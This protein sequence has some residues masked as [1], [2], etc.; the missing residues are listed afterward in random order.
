[1]KGSN[2]I[3]SPDG[4]LTREQ[5]AVIIRNIAITLD[6]D[7]TATE[8]HFADQHSISEWAQTGIDYVASK[9]LM[10]GTGNNNF[11]PKAYMDYEQSYVLLY[12]L[13][14]KLK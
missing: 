6:Q 7:V 8:S 3:F 5:A 11:S 2:K 4:Y 14:T 13:F 1:M 12:R 10:G 9:G